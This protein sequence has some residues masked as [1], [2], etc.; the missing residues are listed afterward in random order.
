MKDMF[1]GCLL[2]YYFRVFERRFGSRKFASYLMVN[3]VVA[4]FLELSTVYF[5]RSFNGVTIDTLPSGPLS[6]I[7]SLFIN[8]FLDI[9]RITQTHILGIPVTGKTLTYLLGLQVI[10]SSRGSLITCASGLLAGIAY[11]LNLLYVSDLFQIPESVANFV[12]RAFGWLLETSPPREGPLLMGATLEIQ[13]QQQIEILEQQMM[14]SRTREMRDRTGGS[15][16]QRARFPD[17]PPP[18]V[19]DPVPG[20]S[21]GNMASSEVIEDQVQ[22]LVEMGFERLQVIRALQ[23]SNNDIN[24]ATSILLQEG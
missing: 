13:R 22:V 19:P 3:C 14:M 5:L 15:G 21:N 9:P 12:S 23:R 17:M 1:C 8:Y 10:T 18:L 7:F 4:T 24:A 2:L 20:P 11:R 16:T 6:V